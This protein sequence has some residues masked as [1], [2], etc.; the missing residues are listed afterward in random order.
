MVR[1]AGPWIGGGGHGWA[2]VVGAL[3]VMKRLQS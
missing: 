1:A 2:F 3:G